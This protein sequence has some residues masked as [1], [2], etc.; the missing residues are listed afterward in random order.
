MSG[1]VKAK[2]SK[3]DDLLHNQTIK[4]DQ[5]NQFPNF[6][7]KD[8]KNKENWRRYSEYLKYNN[9]KIKN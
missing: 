7:H 6:D 4:T 1:K 9:G 2:P 3:I 8:I 5:M